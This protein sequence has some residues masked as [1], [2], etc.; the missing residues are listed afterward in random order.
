MVSVTASLRY[1]KNK[2]Y[3]HFIIIINII[4]G[5]ECLALPLINQSISIK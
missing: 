5:M 3:C 1:P 4:F 2:E